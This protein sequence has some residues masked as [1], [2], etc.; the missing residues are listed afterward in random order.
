MR[1]E[2]MCYLLPQLLI[3]ALLDPIS[4]C[5]LHVYLMSF[6]KMLNLVLECIFSVRS[7]SQ[8]K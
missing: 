8:E 4:M 3:F 1:L 7:Y 6:Y 2:M 5:S